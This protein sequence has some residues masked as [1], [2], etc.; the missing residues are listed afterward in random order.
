MRGGR[1]RALGR[2]PRRRAVRVLLAATALARLTLRGGAILALRRRLDAQCALVACARRRSRG[3]TAILVD[4]SASAAPAARFGARPHTVDAHQWRLAAAGS[5]AAA[6]RPAAA[7][8][9]RPAAA[10]AAARACAGPGRR[11]AP[12]PL[13]MP[14]AH[15]R[16]QGTGPVDVD[17][18]AVLRPSSGAVAVRTQWRKVTVAADV[19]AALLVV[20]EVTLADASA[21]PCAERPDALFRGSSRRARTA[22][23]T[24]SPDSQ[25]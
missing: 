14:C 16:G 1:A 6:R 11:Q 2:V 22:P 17:A 3:R 25:S 10:A 13:R 18:A 24:K 23:R 20:E 15:A 7:A 4:P 21:R 12:L 19:V 9:S 8:P 5:P